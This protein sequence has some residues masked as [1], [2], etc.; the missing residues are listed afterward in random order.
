MAG[1]LPQ[2]VR[3][4]ARHDA[5]R[6]REWVRIRRSEAGIA[7][8]AAHRLEARAAAPRLRQ[9]LDVAD[10]DQAAGRTTADEDV[11]VLR[12]GVPAAVTER[13][14]SA[15]RADLERLVRTVELGAAVSA[16]A[17][18]GQG[19]IGIHVAELDEIGAL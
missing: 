7:K 2:S 9:R 11:S 3:A 18:H 15:A 10:D 5:E 14:G 8:S 4:V 6:E 17:E 19:T 13:R 12:A 16:D 1:R